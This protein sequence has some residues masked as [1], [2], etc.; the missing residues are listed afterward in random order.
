VVSGTPAPPFD[1]DKTFKILL[2]TRENF[3]LLWTLDE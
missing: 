3:L 2:K 1:G